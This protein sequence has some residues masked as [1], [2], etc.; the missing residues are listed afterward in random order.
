MQ[1]PAFEHGIRPGDAAGGPA[2]L[3]RACL[4]EVSTLAITEI[5]SHTTELRG[6]RFLILW[7]ER[8]WR[9][10]GDGMLKQDYSCGCAPHLERLNTLRRP[11]G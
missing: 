8:V 4:R 9:T 2:V 1:S 5:E 6:E 11:Q 10:P 3:G 7:M